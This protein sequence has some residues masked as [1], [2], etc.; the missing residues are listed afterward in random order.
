M[1]MPFNKMIVFIPAHHYNMGRCTI[2]RTKQLNEHLH[3]LAN[4]SH[5]KHV[6]SASSKYNLE[7]LRHYTGLEVLPLYSYCLHVTN[8]T[9]TPTRDEIPIFPQRAGYNNWDERFVIDIKKVKIV[10]F[11]KLY[12]WYSF[13]NLVHHRAIVFLPYAVM[14]YKLTEFYTMGIPLFV[15]SMKYFQTIKPFGPDKTILSKIFCE[16]RGTLRDKQMVPHP[17]SIHP[18]SPNAKTKNLNFIGYSWLTLSSGL[19]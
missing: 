17:N 11:K 4:A 14:T 13:S 2:E 10:D 3:M 1:W 9:Y 6:I 12:K 19:T 5:P 8:N 18:Y 16:G 15:P 7:Y